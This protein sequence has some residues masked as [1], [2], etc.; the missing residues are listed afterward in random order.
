MKR[1]IVD[2]TIKRSIVDTTMIRFIV[3]TFFDDSKPFAII[4]TLYGIRRKT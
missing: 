2:S 4:R 3:V 1:S